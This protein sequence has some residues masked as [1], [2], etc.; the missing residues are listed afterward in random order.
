MEVLLLAAIIGILIVIIFTGNL[1]TLLRWVGQA[2]VK[3]AIGALLLFFLNALGSNFDVHVPINLATAAI[4]GFL[5]IP[6]V[7][8]LVVIDIW[9]V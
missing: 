8:A 6:G 7:L 9:I 3:I 1:I 2:T 5:G 4:S